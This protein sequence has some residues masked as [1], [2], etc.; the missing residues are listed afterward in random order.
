MRE[1]ILSALPESSD[2]LDTILEHTGDCSES[3]RVAAYHILAS[4]FFPLEGFR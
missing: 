2:T 1:G 4:K 3:V